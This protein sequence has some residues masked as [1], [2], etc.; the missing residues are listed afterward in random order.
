MGHCL[1]HKVSRREGELA[2][3][4]EKKIASIRK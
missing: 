4:K 1:D 3:R 2:E